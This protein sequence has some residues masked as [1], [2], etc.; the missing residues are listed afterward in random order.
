MKNQDD[1][2]WCPEPEEHD[3]PAAESYLLLFYENNFVSMLIDKLR[4][5]R[6]THFKAKKAMNEFMAFFLL[7]YEPASID[8]FF[9]SNN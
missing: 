7:F 2:Q 5:E 1:I 8:I 4:K 6:I 3:Y 9:R